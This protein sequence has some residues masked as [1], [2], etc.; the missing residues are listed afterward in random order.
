MEHKVESL[1][2]EQTME[3]SWV[4]I[5]QWNFLVVEIC[6][7]IC[8]YFLF[9]RP[10]KYWSRNTTAIISFVL[11]L[12][13]AGN[14]CFYLLEL[15]WA[16]LFSCCVVVIVFF[17]EIV[18]NWWSVVAK[19]LKQEQKCRVIL[20]ILPRNN[21]K[22]ERS[23]RKNTPVTPLSL[24]TLVILNKFFTVNEQ[25]AFFLCI[26]VHLFL[27]YTENFVWYLLEPC[28]RKLKSCLFLLW[29]VPL[30]INFPTKKKT[31]NP[32]SAV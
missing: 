24:I 29:T 14:R 1:D 21:Y 32:N 4:P 9:F 20:L 31:G 26:N 22:R 13:V 23:A 25:K 2:R 3:L 5:S 18:S 8:I 6:V 17:L 10:I 27:L 16:S 7:P 15:L 30:G 12:K 19:L 11:F 28:L